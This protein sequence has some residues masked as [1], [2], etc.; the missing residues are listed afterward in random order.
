MTAVVWRLA[1]MRDALLPRDL[2]APQSRRPR[3]HRPRWCCRPH[4]RRRA[5][6]DRSRRPP[7][8]RRC[9]PAAT[10]RACAT[11]SAWSR[12]A[13]FM[14]DLKAPRRDRGD[15]DVVLDQ[16]RRHPARQMDHRGLARGIGVGLHRVDE[17]AVDRGDVDHLARPVMR[18][19]R[20]AAAWPA[21]WSGRRST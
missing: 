21:P 20:R 18:S 8:P 19:P 13:R 2:R 11:S 15:V 16:P 17:D 3:R 9:R 10:G 5:R 1:P 6:R 12:A 4:S 14:S 7:C